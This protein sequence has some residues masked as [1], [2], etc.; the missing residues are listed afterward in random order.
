MPRRF[1]DTCSDFSSCGRIIGDAFQSFAQHKSV[2]APAQPVGK[3]CPFVCW[4][5]IEDGDGSGDIALERAEHHCLRRHI[6]FRIKEAERKAVGDREPEE[7]NGEDA[8][9]QRAWPR[10]YAG[11]AAERHGRGS[12][13]SI[14]TENT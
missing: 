6:A 14:G 4:K 9:A 13:I 2:I 7:K 10:H 5:A 3:I 12:D 1:L 11:N 8:G